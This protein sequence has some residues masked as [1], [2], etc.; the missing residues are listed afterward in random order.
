MEEWILRSQISPLECGQA[1]YFTS[2]QGSSIITLSHHLLSSSLPMKQS[3]WPFYK[4]TSLFNLVRLIIP[5][6]PLIVN[7]PLSQ[8]CH[9]CC[10]PLIP[11]HESLLQDTV[12][13]SIFS[14][15]YPDPKSQF[16]CCLLYQIISISQECFELDT[17]IRKL[18]YK[19]PKSSRSWLSSSAN[20]N[21][22]GMKVT[23]HGGNSSWTCWVHSVSIWYLALLIV[24][25]LPSD[26]GAFEAAPLLLFLQLVLQ[27]L[28]LPLLAFP[29]S[30]L[31][32]PRQPFKIVVWK[33]EI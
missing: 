27:W 26:P 25:A 22:R 16:L 13:L 7:S 23:P 17:H 12:K 29:C 3:L 18:L 15:T 30:I 32:T 31:C 1:L 14:I 11:Y 8:I 33:P 21:N 24:G 28:K 2:A 5:F 19:V 4:L 9:N 6:P 20:R 10:V